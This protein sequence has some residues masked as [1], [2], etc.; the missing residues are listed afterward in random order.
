M[1]R[2]VGQAAS[3][4]Y[5]FPQFF[6][7]SA[8][9]TT[10]RVQLPL[11]REPVLPFRQP[12][13]VLRAFEAFVIYCN[14][15]IPANTGNVTETAAKQSASQWADMYKG[16]PENTQIYVQQTWPQ[17]WVISRWVLY[18]TTSGNGYWYAVPPQASICG[19]GG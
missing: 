4:Y 6:T 14:G 9:A 2:R 11:G 3:P 16:A 7:P 5:Q 15:Q 1:N 10:P 12:P 13:I 19:I 17:K 18:R 8:F